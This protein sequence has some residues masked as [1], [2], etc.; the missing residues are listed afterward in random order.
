MTTLAINPNASL[1]PTDLAEL[2]ATFN[3][4]T[5]KLQRTHDALSAEVARLKGELASAN[6][7]L[8]RSRELAA[9]GEMAAGI[10]HEVRNPLGSIGLYATMLRE[11]LAD[12][13]EQAG[14]AQKI[15][16]AVRGLDR[17][18]GDVLSFAREVRVRPTPVEAEALV[19]R[20]ID[21]CA[22]DAALRDVAIDVAADPDSEASAS[23][24][25]GL[26]QQALLNV[27][28]NAIQAADEN[29]EHRGDAAWVAVE[30]R[31]STLRSTRGGADEA[32]SIVIRDSG[33]GASDE[34]M[35][36]MFNP[37]FTTRAAGT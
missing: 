24:D 28:R 10:A 2:M 14:V 13:P 18:V 16:D 21:V 9:L 7:Q 23:C 1:S 11:D 36:R 33:A 6:A 31:D 22:A 19:R 29:R 4:V 26:I 35:R 15:G 34:V 12:R 32:V 3:E 25:P 20:V 37:F 8:R 5:A 30:I 27:L 17:I